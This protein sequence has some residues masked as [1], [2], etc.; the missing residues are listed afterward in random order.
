MRG[1]RGAPQQRKCVGCSNS[2]INLLPTMLFT[3]LESRGL[4]L[5]SRLFVEPFLPNRLDGGAAARR[6]KGATADWSDLRAVD[7]AV[8][9]C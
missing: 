7:L 9:W 1:P 4:Q 3:R 6:G 5:A 2:F 8:P